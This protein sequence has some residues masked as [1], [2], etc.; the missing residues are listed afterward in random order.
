MDLDDEEE[1]T[2][3]EEEDPPDVLQTRPIRPS[4]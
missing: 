4:H 2:F 3:G 1:E